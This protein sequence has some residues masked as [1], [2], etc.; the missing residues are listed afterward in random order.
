MFEDFKFLTTKKSKN[1]KICARV[2][3]LGS[4]S[5]NAVQW[6]TSFKTVCISYSVFSFDTD[7]T[8]LNKT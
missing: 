8:K 5:E 2:D 7:G 1:A 6:V 3:F 4:G